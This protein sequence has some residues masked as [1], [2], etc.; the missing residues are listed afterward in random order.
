MMQDFDWTP[1]A[2]GGATR[3]D[4]FSG[5]ADPFQR[6]LSQLIASAP[7]EIRPHLQI[8][9]GY[10]SPERQAQLWE[11]ALKKYGSPEAARKW[12]AP[13]GKSNHNHGKAADLKYGSDAARQWAHQNAGQFGLAFP[14]SNEPW[15]IELASARGGPEAP[16]NALAPQDSHSHDPRPQ[17]RED[18]LDL[19]MRK[20]AMLQQLMPQAQ[21]LDPRAFQVQPIA[22]NALALKPY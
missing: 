9:S 2:V 4:S 6:S 5:M 1:Y 22:Q 8:S 12:V 3:P 18:D 17:G 16:A 10:R 14:L 20:L 15:H 19:Q 7:E 21:Q 13:P 11:E